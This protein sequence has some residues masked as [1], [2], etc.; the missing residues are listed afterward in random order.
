VQRL[1]RI[2]MICREPDRLADFYEAA[3]GFTPTGEVSINEPAL[4][5]LVRIPG[6]TARVVTLQL[7]EQE[8][9]LAGIRPPGHSYPR[10]VPGPSPLFQHCAIVVSDMA[11][12]YE[13]LSG[14]ADWNTISPDGPQVLPASSGGVTAYKFRDP[15][16]HPLELLAFARDTIPARWQNFSAGGCLGIDHSAISIA[17]TRRSVKFYE[18]LGLSCIGSSLNCGPEQ[19]RLDG[20]AEAFVEVTAMALPINTTPHVELLCYRGR[21]AREW[22]LPNTNDVAA[23]RLVLAV[24]N[25]ETLQ[26]LCAQCSDALLSGPVRF[27]NGAMR[28]MVRDPDGHV[29]CLEAACN[30]SFPKLNR[31]AAVT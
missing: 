23:T 18:W 8:I 6:A 30:E 2:T 11:A 15:E 16:G 5:E 1:S 12:A 9:G 14:Q 19:D 7:G 13:R 24:D 25:H 21:R 10:N 17:D 20:I 22:A 4:A 3:F 31:D 27:E 29:L 28:A 26:A